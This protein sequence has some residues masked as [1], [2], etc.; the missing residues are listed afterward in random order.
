[1]PVQPSAALGSAI[2]KR[3]RWSGP[4]DAIAAL[5]IILL[6]ILHD[7]FYVKGCFEFW[8]CPRGKSVKK[9]G[10]FLGVFVSVWLLSC[11]GW[12]FILDSYRLIEV[13]INLLIFFGNSYSLIVVLK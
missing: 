2:I 9:N 13:F 4:R 12:L 10:G 8:V 7:N 1:M 11:A 3:Y 5:G 6:C